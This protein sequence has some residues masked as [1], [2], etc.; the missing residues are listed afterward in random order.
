MQDTNITNG[1]TL[2]DEVEINL[3]VLRALMLHW[4]GGHVHSADV[5]AVDQRSAVKGSVEL[6]QELAQLGCLGNAIRHC[7]ILSFSTG[8]GDGVLAL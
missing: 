6:R 1:D 5:V 2:S 8:S 3:D 7:A 4:V